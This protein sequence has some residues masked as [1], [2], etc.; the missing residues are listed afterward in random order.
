M[1]NKETNNAASK[2]KPG[3]KVYQTDGARVY[4]STVR[5]I[6]FDADGLVFDCC[7]VGKSVFLTR[8]DAE[9]RI[10]GN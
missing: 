10:S 2:L 1:D 5:R 3:D 8:E 6:L 7:A 4:E 9:A